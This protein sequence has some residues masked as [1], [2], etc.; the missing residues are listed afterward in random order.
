VAG[1]NATGRNCGWCISSSLV[2]IHQGPTSVVDLVYVVCFL[3]ASCVFLTH[4]QSLMHHVL[5]SAPGLP[6]MNV[7]APSI[8]RRQ[9]VTTSLPPS[10]PYPSV[11]TLLRPWGCHLASLS[12]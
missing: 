4:H 12:L 6:I 7:N 11:V 3:F 9:L 10:P 2:H 5:P 1:G 8:I